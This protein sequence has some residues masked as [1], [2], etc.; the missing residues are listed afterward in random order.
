MTTP[1]L[2]ASGEA[3]A[4]RLCREIGWLLGPLWTQY[5]QGEKRGCRALR[6]RNHPAP[7]RVNL[8]AVVH[9]RGGLGTH[10]R[11]G[12]ARPAGPF[13]AAGHAAAGTNPEPPR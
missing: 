4:A 8:V 2:E 5:A 6:G 1:S 7:H 11:L 10:M 3:R 9:Q 13:R 12:P